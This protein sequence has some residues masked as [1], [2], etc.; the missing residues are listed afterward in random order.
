MYACFRYTS[1]ENLAMATKGV[2]VDFG[3]RK[4]DIEVPNSSAVVE[5]QDHSILAD[6]D[7]AVRRALDVPL[8]AAP[9]ADLAQPKMRVAIGFDDITRPN[10]PARTILPS[11]VEKLKR[12]G[13][14]E[15]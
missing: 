6:P 8:G 2:A 13:I 12:A 7:A 4:I 5:F 1:K 10:I 14:R 9:L 15:R 3:D 11:V